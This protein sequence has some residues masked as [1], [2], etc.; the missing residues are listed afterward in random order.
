MSAVVTQPQAGDKHQ[1]FPMVNAPP[2]TVNIPPGLPPGLA[3]LGAIE[4]VR[5]HQQLELLEGKNLILKIA[6]TVAW[7]FIIKVCFA[8]AFYLHSAI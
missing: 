5:V 6:F 1:Q 2:P 4:E 8:I 7:N 3:Y